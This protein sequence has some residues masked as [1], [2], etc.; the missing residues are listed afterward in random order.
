M[1]FWCLNC[2]TS[3]DNISFK[4]INFLSRLGRYPFEASF[5]F[6]LIFSFFQFSFFLFF[7]KNV[8]LFSVFATSSLCIRVY[9]RCFLRSWC[10]M[11]MWCLD[12]TGRDSWDWVGPPAWRRACFNSPEWGAG[13]SPVRTEPLQ[14]VL[15]LLFWTRV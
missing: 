6:F 9:Q 2:F 12:D 15:L 7:L 13:S 4:K 10:S 8:F 1:I 11:E 3:S 14:I 5:P